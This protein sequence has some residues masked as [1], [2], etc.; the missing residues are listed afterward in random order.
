V[1]ADARRAHGPGD[2]LVAG[3]AWA[4]L[5]VMRAL[6]L[7][8]PFARLMTLAG[9]RLVAPEAASGAEPAESA[10]AARDRVAPGAATDPRLDRVAWGID[11]AAR[12][13][14]WQSRCLAQSLAGA[15]MLRLRGEP[16]LVYFGVRPAGPAA[17]RPMTAHS[18]LVSGGR[19]LTGAAGQEQYG[20]V[21][22]YRS[23]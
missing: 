23:A 3:E 4:L 1:A 17:N 19:I 11:A 2:V 12:R 20:V 7:G 22:V 18:W 16:T 6:L 15:V 21:A 9:M 8:V 10:A 14:P 5:G 13:T